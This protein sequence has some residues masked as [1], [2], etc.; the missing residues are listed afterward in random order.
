MYHNRTYLYAMKKCKACGKKILGRADKIFCS[1]ICKS[2]SHRQK[3]SSNPY[4][5]DVNKI[6]RRNYDILSSLF[7]KKNRKQISINHLAL[8]KLGFQFEY[9]TR[10]YL[11]SKGKW[12]YYVYDIR[13]M[14]FSDQN[15]IIYRC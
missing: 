11:N 5:S 14:E 10:V 1:A 7:D 3:V 2:R 8:T 13:W 9:C 4:L 15:I 12:C 6:L